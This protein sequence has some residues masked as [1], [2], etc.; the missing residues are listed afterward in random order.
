MPTSMPTPI[1]DAHN[2]NKH[3]TPNP[4]S[5]HIIS[6]YAPIS[7]L[8]N[9]NKYPTPNTTLIPSHFT[10]IPHSENTNQYPPPI[11]IPTTSYHISQ[12]QNINKSLSVNP[13]TNASDFASIPHST[14]PPY[15]TPNPLNITSNP[16]DFASI[17]NKTQNHHISEL[18]SPQL[19]N[20]N[21]T[22]TL[23]TN[24]LSL[25]SLG[26]PKPQ[27]NSIPIIQSVNNL[28]EPYRTMQTTNNPIIPF[29]IPT[30]NVNIGTDYCQKLTITPKTQTNN[31]LQYTDIAQETQNQNFAQYLMETNIKCNY[32]YSAYK[33]K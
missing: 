13:T 33:K 11:E 9:I 25:P 18:R 1:H 8:H 17:P 4:H 24:V 16:L 23:H 20:T 26:L 12:S 2:T 5:H 27:I 6:N 21:G 29:K 10:S 22:K 31:S 30:S 3:G 19:C 28:N 32:N 15:I 7:D 14:S